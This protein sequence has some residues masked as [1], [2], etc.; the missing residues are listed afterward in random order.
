V[1]LAAGADRGISDKYG[2]SAF[3]IGLRGKLLDAAT[4]QALEPTTG[5]SPPPE[6]SLTG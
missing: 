4:L 3:E 1:L 6:G 5:R 2:D